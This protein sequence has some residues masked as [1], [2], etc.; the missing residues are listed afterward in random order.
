MI[1]TLPAL[2]RPTSLRWRLTLTYTFLI[3]GTLLLLG[4][5]LYNL[6]AFQLERNRRDT[7]IDQTNSFADRA[8]RQSPDQTP[9]WLISTSSGDFLANSLARSAPSYTFRIYDSSGALRGASSALEVDT[10][11]LVKSVLQTSSAPDPVIQTTQSGVRHMYVLRLIGSPDQ[12]LGVVEVSSSLYDIDLMLDD[13]RRVLLGALTGSLL[14]SVGLGLYLAHTVT[15][16]LLQVREVAARVAGGDFTAHV[17][18]P[19]PDEVGDLART[20]NF[21]ASELQQIDDLR[22]Q[23]VSNVSHELKT[24]LTAIKGFVVTSLDDPEDTATQRRA[25]EVIDQEADRLSRLVDELLSF[26]RLEAGK[27]HLRSERINLGLLIEEVVRAQSPRS[28]RYRITIQTRLS[29]GLWLRADRDKLKQILINLLDNSL[30]FTPPGG[31]ITIS[32][33]VGSLPASFQMQNELRQREAPHVQTGLQRFMG[34]KNH[35]SNNGMPVVADRIREYIIVRVADT[36]IGIAAEDLPHIFERFYRG[37]TGS[38]TRNG[39]EA[40]AGLTSGTGLGLSIVR[41][42]VEAHCGYIGIE[43]TPHVGTTVTVVLPRND[44]EQRREQKHTKAEP[45]TRDK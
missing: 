2:I 11:N 45:H 35:S 44:V 28:E 31:T 4:I 36:G 42:L 24:P 21:M 5:L 3:A 22:S 16:P 38:G 9:E 39:D 32:A 41:L 23:F 10:H 19:S 37:H 15:N 1:R 29:T 6:F 26:A 8:A 27:V 18:R 43:S 25:L 17:E 40:D 34:G 20:V 7:L 12:P 13:F 14:L 30:K 33:Q